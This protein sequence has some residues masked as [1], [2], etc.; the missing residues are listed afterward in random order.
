MLEVQRTA[1][2]A[3][4]RQAN[5]KIG[6]FRMPRTL[7]LGLAGAAL[8]IGSAVVDAD[9]KHRKKRYRADT[10]KAQERQAETQYELDRARSVGGYDDPITAIGKFLN[11]EPAGKNLQEDYLVVP[12]PNGRIWD[13]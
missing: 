12:K 9:A 13:N 6:D 2:R 5:R 7:I 8:L 3:F 11:G 10:N 4:E 1:R